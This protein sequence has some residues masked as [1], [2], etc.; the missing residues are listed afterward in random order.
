MKKKI[1]EEEAK[2]ILSLNREHGRE[3]GGPSEPPK[4]SSGLLCRMS[5]I[6]EIIFVSFI[7]FLCVWYMCK[8]V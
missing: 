4:K 2:I 1:Q 7:H 8:L 5:I 3:H 6:V